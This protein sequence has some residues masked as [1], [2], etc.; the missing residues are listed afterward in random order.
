ME[1][2]INSMNLAELR[3]ER[4]RLDGQIKQA[5]QNVRQLWNT[6]LDACEEAL[7]TWLLAEQIGFTSR[8]R[9]NAEIWDI[10]GGV[11][12][13]T[14]ATDDEHYGPGRMYAKTGALTLEW[15]EVPT[16]QRFIAIIAVLLGVNPD[17]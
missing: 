9:K 14:F 13:V 15:T 17:A 3:A 6:A 7:G 2:D 10:A 8:E 1:K 5:E 16:P 4:E 11:M 12:E